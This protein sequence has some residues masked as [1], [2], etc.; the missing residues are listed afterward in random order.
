MLINS[1]AH[2]PDGL[3]NE[4]DSDDVKRES[5]NTDS[6]SMARQPSG[7]VCRRQSGSSDEDDSCG[8]KRKRTRGSNYSGGRCGGLDDNPMPVPVQKTQPL[9]IGDSAEVRRFYEVR[10]K[11]MQQWAC[12]IIGKIF[13]RTIEPKKQTH[14]PYTKGDEAAPPWWLKTSG[15]DGVRHK[16]PDHLLRPGKY[17]KCFHE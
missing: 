16:E 10:F 11:D 4:F 6:A 13:V 2:A 14:Y 7:I 17:F 5:M 1:S 3:F 12:K 15:P 8:G 9:I